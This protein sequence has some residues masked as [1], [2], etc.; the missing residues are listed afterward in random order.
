MQAWNRQNPS[1]ISFV[2]SAK[3]LYLLLPKN[4]TA[5]MTARECS[6]PVHIATR[7]L[8]LPTA[9]SALGVEKSWWVSRVLA[10]ALSFPRFQR[11]KKGEVKDEVTII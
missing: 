4:A 2:P 9:V 10:R 3:G 7:V 6:R 5:P 11:S 1:V 8:T